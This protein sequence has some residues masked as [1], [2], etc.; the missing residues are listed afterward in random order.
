MFPVFDPRRTAVLAY[1]YLDSTGLVKEVL[2][3]FSHPEVVQVQAVEGTGICFDPGEVD[4]TH[5]SNEVLS[6]YILLYHHRQW[7]SKSYLI[8]YI[9]EISRPNVSSTLLSMHYPIM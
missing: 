3:S 4:L 9:C 5:V 1:V 8:G 2:D 6:N 7:Q